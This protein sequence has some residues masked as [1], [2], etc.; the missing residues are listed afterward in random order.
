MATT[1]WPICTATA[2]STICAEGVP[3]PEQFRQRRLQPGRLRLV[4][5]HDAGV[6]RIAGDEVLVVG[7]G[8][9]GV[10]ATHPDRGG[11]R[12]RP[13]ARAPGGFPRKVDPRNG[14]FMAARLAIG[15]VD[16]SPAVR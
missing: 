10:A 15:P 6:G 16:V 14:T 3:L 11:W 13:P 7:L 8:V 1:P 2:P 4:V 12:P 5:D 9:A